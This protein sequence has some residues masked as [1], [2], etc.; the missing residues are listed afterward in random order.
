MAS[1]VDVEGIGP[2][3]AEKLKEKG[4][5]TTEALLKAGATAKGREGLAAA[6]GIS[7]KTAAHAEALLSSDRP[8]TS[9]HPTPRS[10]E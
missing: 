2:A 9:V 10:P 4:I 8:F 1:I 3:Y 7:E 5:T 6:T